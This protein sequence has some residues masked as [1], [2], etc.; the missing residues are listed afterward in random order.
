MLDALHWH[1]MS[2]L[3]IGSTLAAPIAVKLSHRISVKLIMV[4]VGVIVVSASGFT[5]FKSLFL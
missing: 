4:A 1:S 2:G 3:V 5:I